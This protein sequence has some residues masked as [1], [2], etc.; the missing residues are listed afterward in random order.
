MSPLELVATDGHSGQAAPDL[1]ATDRR[2]WPEAAPASREG[3][4][5]VVPGFVGADLEGR[6]VTLGRGGSD[7][8]ATLLGQALAARRFLWKD[9]EG[10]LTADP[11]SCRTPA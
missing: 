9:V 1:A 6:P 5:P 7:L 10:F 8:T 11:A 4:V 3:V 2:N